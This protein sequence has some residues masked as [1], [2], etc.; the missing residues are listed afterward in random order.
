MVG[1][2]SVTDAIIELAAVRVD[3]LEEEL[4]DFPMPSRDG[5]ITIDQVRIDVRKC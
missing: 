4:G 3:K 1:V 5:S 2:G